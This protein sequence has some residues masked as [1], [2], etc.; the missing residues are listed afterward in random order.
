M[1]RGKRVL[2]MLRAHRMAR[3]RKVLRPPDRALDPRYADAGRLRRCAEG[4][5][6]V[7]APHL[8]GAPDQARTRGQGRRERRSLAAHRMRARLSV[9]LHAVSVRR[10]KKWALKNII[11]RLKGGERWALIGQNGSGK[12]QLLKLIAADVWPTPTGREK[13]VYR[14]GAPQFDPDRGE[15]ADRLSRQRAAGQI[16]ALRLGSRACAI[17]SPRACTA[18]ICCS[19]RSPP[20]SAGRSPRRSA[21][22]GLT[23]LGDRTLLHRC[24]MGR[25]GLAL[26]A[27][28]LCQAPD[29]LLL[30]EFYNGLDAALPRAH[31]PDA[32]RGARPGLIMDRGGAS[33]ARCSRGA[34]AG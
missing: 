6:S 29:W 19:R 32:R 4:P 14:V 5:A 8:G 23:R 16:L 33:R 2:A 26:L 11:A 34:P 17:C 27:R 18:P 20:P 9:A 28:A 10:G 3:E 31:R 13:L 24:P 7:G 12:T 21:A 1:S 22:C 15:A 25:N 30:D